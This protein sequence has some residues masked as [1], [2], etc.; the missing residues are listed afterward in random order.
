[1]HGLAYEALRGGGRPRARRVEALTGATVDANSV[2]ALVVHAAWRRRRRRAR[3]HWKGGDGEAAEV[4][5]AAA[6]T[7]TDT[8]LVV[9]VSGAADASLRI[10]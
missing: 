1:M 10:L 2:R 5:A 6:A 8:D 9:T 7:A 4:A 3:R